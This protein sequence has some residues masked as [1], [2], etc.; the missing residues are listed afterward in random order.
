MENEITAR[1]KFLLVGVLKGLFMALEQSA[2]NLA[3]RR[4]FDQLMMTIRPLILTLDDEW[5]TSEDEVLDKW[6]NDVQND[7]Q[8]ILEKTNGES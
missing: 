1:E 6:F 2:M 8:N 5:I 7:V 4:F 3:D